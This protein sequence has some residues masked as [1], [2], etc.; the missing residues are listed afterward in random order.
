MESDRWRGFL[1]NQQGGG[2][3]ERGCI[4]KMAFFL[5]KDLKKKKKDNEWDG[6]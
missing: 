4:R 2:K 3:K 1:A 5:S 6:A